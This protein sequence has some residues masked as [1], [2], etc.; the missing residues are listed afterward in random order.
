MNVNV[1][2]NAAQNKQRKYTTKSSESILS[3]GVKLDHFRDF[4]LA[5]PI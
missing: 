5:S 2:V 4:Y 1:D 3:I